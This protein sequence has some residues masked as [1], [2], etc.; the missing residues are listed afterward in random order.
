MKKIILLSSLIFIFFSCENNTE[1]ENSIQGKWYVT[2]IIGG[3]LPTKSYNEGNFTWFFDL[4]QKTVTI[5]NNVDVFNTLH[6]PSFT[7]NQGGTYSFEIKIE[8]NVEYLVVDDR[9]GS[10][11]L[12]NNELTIDY[13]IASDDIAYNFKR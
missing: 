9:E 8:N 12:I 10:I 7:N 6:I 3:F 2:Q 5:V 13:G 4:D 11:K 1:I